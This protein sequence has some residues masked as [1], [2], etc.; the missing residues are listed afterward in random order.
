[1]SNQK[2]LEFEGLEVGAT[3]L[4]NDSQNSWVPAIIEAIHPKRTAKGEIDQE[5]APDLA[6]IIFVT[7]QHL[8]SFAAPRVPH[9]KGVGNWNLR[10][11][12]LRMQRD[13]DKHRNEAE[14]AQLE[15][16]KALEKAALKE[17]ESLVE[18]PPPAPPA[19]PVPPPPPPPADLTPPP[20]PEEKAAEKPQ[21]EKPP[22]PEEKAEAPA[23]KPKDKKQA[24]KL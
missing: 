14:K 24:T 15:H 16:L 11:V 9:G 3:V 2:L 18:P 4:Y 7:G 8:S 13:P 21:E 22:A 23:D 6:L 1:M 17:A 19:P 5:K 10:E 20:P 12:V